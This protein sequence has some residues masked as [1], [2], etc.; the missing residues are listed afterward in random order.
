MCI[1]Y[2]GLPKMA[3]L[4]KYPFGDNIDMSQTSVFE[5][6]QRL[7]PKPVHSS[8]NVIPISTSE[9]TFYRHLHTLENLGFITKSSRG[10]F[11]TNDI[12]ISQPAVIRDKLSSS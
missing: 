4:Y 3:E 8:N 2:K 1:V 9:R 5:F 6:A 7:G 11:M 12:A 10:Y